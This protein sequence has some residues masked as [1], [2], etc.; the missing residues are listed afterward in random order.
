M[1][2]RAELVKAYFSLPSPEPI[3]SPTPEPFIEA[4]LTTYAVPVLEP[5]VPHY[6]TCTHSHMLTSLMMATH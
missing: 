2:I 6:L 1:L 3:P 4:V 5:V